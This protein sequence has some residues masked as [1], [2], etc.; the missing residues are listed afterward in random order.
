MKFIRILLMMIG[1]QQLTTGTA[2]TC[3]AAA[4]GSGSKFNNRSTY[5]I[6]DAILCAKIKFYWHA[7]LALI[8]KTLLVRANSG[9]LL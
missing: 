9:F 7:C 2:V 4:S 6:Y 5:I 3:N 1:L 8:I